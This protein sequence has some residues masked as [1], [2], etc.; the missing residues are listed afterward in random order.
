MTLVFAASL[1][2][3]AAVLTG[4]ATLAGSRTWPVRQS[5]TAESSGMVRVGVQHSP[6]T[7]TVALVW[8]GDLPRPLQQM[9]FETAD[10]VTAPARSRCA[11]LISLTTA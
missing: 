2:R 7:A 5:G 9:L 10:N 1:D 3:P 6:L 11:E 4:P 8:S